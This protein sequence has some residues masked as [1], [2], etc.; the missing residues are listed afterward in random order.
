MKKEILNP[1]LRGRYS[2]MSAEEL[3]AEA[4]R[5]DE[6]FIA[7]EAKP[8]TAEIKAKLGRAKRKRGRPRLGK[9]TKR[10]LV[11]VERDLLRRTDALARKMKVSR[12]SLIA[13]GLTA[14]LAEAE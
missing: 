4:E 9:G 12:A 2:R 5:F 3:D 1:K 10:I 6:E 11:T 8:L 7:D 14:V 13:R